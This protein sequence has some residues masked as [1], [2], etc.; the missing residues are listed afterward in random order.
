MGD[1]PTIADIA[2]ELGVSPSTVSR[3]LRDHP[4]ISEARKAEVRAAAE[5]LGF[6]VKAAPYSDASLVRPL[7]ACIVPSLSHPFMSNFVERL[8]AEAAAR[9]YHLLV[10]NSGGS[11][12][13]EKTIVDSLIARRVDGVFFIP[14]SFESTSL[15][16]CR[17]ALTT[18]IVT[19]VAPEW[20]SIG[21]SHE[22]GGALV[23]EHFMEQSRSSCL[24]I[25]P[26]YENEGK[27][28]GFRNYLTAR[29]VTG[30]RFEQLVA[31]GWDANLSAGVQN[32][33]L[34]RYN[35]DSIRQFDCI[36][37]N[38]DIV[39]IGAL[40]ALQDLGVSIPS[41]I[42]VAGFDDT[43]LARE[44]RPGLT[45]VAQSLGQMVRSAFFLLLRLQAEE[46]IPAGERCIRLKPHLV[47]RGSTFLGP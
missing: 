45:S 19:Q 10:A 47:V 3:A 40:H 31:D 37:G 1:R 16:E 29:R 4:A 28:Q 42:A 23:A 7:V 27:F 38:N 13:T 43:P 11:P 12:N 15:A 44:V 21:T 25:G 5:S 34:A 9:G 18:V 35:A 2:K 20:P 14:T 46:A 33:I 41:E 32:T 6:E 17:A 24:F 30:F 36:F 26:R 8:E 22:E 39:A